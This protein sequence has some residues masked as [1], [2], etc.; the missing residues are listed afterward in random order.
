MGL[1]EITL[2]VVIVM[3]IVDGLLFMYEKSKAIG[4]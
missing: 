1:Y 4:E 3:L 2:V